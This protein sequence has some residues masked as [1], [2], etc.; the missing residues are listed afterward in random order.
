MNI[1]T[2][3]FNLRTSKGIKQSEMAEKLGLE[4]SGYSRIEKRGNKISYDLIEKIA[5]ILG[6]APAKLLNL[7]VQPEA[8]KEKRILAH[9]IEI[10]TKDQL[11]ID[12]RKIK[13]ITEEALEDFCDMIDWE[14][15]E[16]YI[17]KIYELGIVEEEITEGEY[18]ENDEEVFVMNV[19]EGEEEVVFHNYIFKNKTFYEYF[20][21]GFYR[22]SK[23]THPIVMKRYL[24]YFKSY[25]TQKKSKINNLEISNIPHEKFISLNKEGDSEL[26]SKLLEANGRIKDKERIIRMSDDV[27]ENIINSIDSAIQSIFLEIWQYFDERENFGKAEVRFH[28]KTKLLTINEYYDQPVFNDSP[29]K[30]DLQQIIFSSEEINVLI[31]KMYDSEWNYLALLG[32]SV[33]SELCEHDDIIEK[34]LYLKYFQAYNKPEEEDSKQKIAKN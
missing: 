30:Y 27:L 24:K 21:K 19:K 18:G 33:I 2:N 20:N 4:Q 7:D 16:T 22:Y 34:S 32:D 29:I 1:G 6:V 15:Q 3:I 13:E 28:G 12:L 11:I 31:S 8:E 14:I 26:Y 5:E 10:A 17:S 9:Q 23:S 25:N